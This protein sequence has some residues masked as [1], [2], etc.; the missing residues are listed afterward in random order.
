MGNLTSQLPTIFWILKSMNFAL[1][2]SFWM[3]RAYFLEASRESSSDF[4]PVTT[5]LPEAK[6]SAVVFGSRILMM[7][8][9]NRCRL[10]RSDKSK[11]VRVWYLWIV[12]CIAGM[13]GDRLQIEPTIKIDGSDDVPLQK[14]YLARLPKKK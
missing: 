11:L 3:I 5:I 8:A 9:A 13:E 10:A 6:M 2:P 1:K 4:A 14:R 7:T 12:L